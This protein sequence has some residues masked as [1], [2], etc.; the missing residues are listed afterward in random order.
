MN[1]QVCQDGR[2]S[3]ITPLSRKLHKLLLIPSNT[4]SLPY[5]DNDAIILLSK[6][7]TNIVCNMQ[8]DNNRQNYRLIHL[9]RF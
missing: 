5:Y 8:T 9:Q 1:K 4:S 6:W 3:M 7:K 2:Q